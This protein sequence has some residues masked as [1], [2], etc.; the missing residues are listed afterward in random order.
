MTTEERLAKHG[1]A[2]DEAARRATARRIQHRRSAPAPVNLAT[3]GP[4]R[5]RVKRLGNRIVFDTLAGYTYCLH[6]S[7]CN[8]HGKALAWV[9]HLSTKTWMTGQ[10]ICDFIDILDE[11]GV[12]VNRD[13]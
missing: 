8:T 9:R 5:L 6:L 2:R 7:R 4:A 10:M 13:L 3:A 1:E 11:A 12:R